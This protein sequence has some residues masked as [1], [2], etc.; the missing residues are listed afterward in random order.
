MEIS[1]CMYKP[2]NIFASRLFRSASSGGLALFAAGLLAISGCSSNNSSLKPQVGAIA[3]TDANA[4]AQKPLTSLTVSQGTYLDVA[5]TNDP[6]LLGADWSVVCGSALAPGAPLPPGQTQDESCGTFTPGHTMSGPV[7]SYVT[8]GA[9]YVTFYTAPAIPPKQGTVTVFASATSDHSRFA[10]VTLAIG[11]LP[12]SVGFAPAPPSIL[13]MGA[14]TQFKAVLNND[15]TN[16]GVNWTVL[17]GSSSCGSVNPTQ[18][19]GGVLVTYTAPATVPTGG[20]V[21]V[22]ATSIA[23]PTKSASATIQI[24]PISVSVSPPILS[25]GTAGT[26]TLVATVLNDASSKGADWSV[27]CTNTTTPGNCGTITSHTASGAP[28]TYTAPSLANIAV[29]STIVVTATSTTDPTK[30]AT[31]TV[32][33]TK[34]NFVAGTS[35]SGQQPISGAQ[36]TLYAAATNEVALNTTANASNVSA[37]TTATTDQDGNFSIPYGY[38]CPTPNTQMYLVSTGGNAGGGTNPNLV[39]MSVLGRCSDLDASRF[40]VNEVTTVAAVY[41][42]SDFMADVQR[43]GSTC[44]SSAGMSVAFSTARDLAD[45]TTGVAR[46]RTVSGTGI[47]PQAQIN[48]L[49]N[50]LNACAKTAGSVQ[51]DGS[52]CDELFHATNPGTIPA[53]QPGNTLLSLLDL[54]RNATGFANNS[55]SFAVL[56]QL[57]ISRASFGPALS[58]KPGDWILAIRFPDGSKGP[59]IAAPEASSTGNLTTNS[60]NPTVDAAGNVWVYSSGNAAT[61]FVGAASSAG[62]PKALIPIAAISGSVP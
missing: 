37:V 10:S 25:V 18:T 50:L 5:L 1:I 27:S 6:Q 56:Y 60:T 34:G 41:A 29:G 19:A 55:N 59:G 3:F 20:T 4:V 8:S 15:A 7:P 52:L 58:A 36:V 30:S 48:T 31:S 47:V 39:L 33:T 44:T 42:L 57:A 49:A 13:G 26:G 61:E 9:G 46:T 62:A 12:I 14:T 21:K 23:D 24:V 28:A 51:G 32:T 17:C 43:V 38:E 54:A 22:T 40:V 45:V 11:G 16:A 53:T 2:R 35:Q